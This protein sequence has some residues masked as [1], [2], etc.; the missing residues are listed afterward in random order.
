MLFGKIHDALSRALKRPRPA[1][2]QGEVWAI[3]EGLGARTRPAVQT[4]ACDRSTEAMRTGHRGGQAREPRPTRALRAGR[5]PD[6]MRPRGG[7]ELGSGTREGRWGGRRGS[8][9]RRRE[10][11]VRGLTARVLVYYYTDTVSGSLE[12]SQ[13]TYT[14]TR[15]VPPDPPAGGGSPSRTS[16][17]VAAYRGARHGRHPGA[18]RFLGNQPQRGDARHQGSQAKRVPAAP[19]PSGGAAAVQERPGLGAMA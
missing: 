13:W 19:C 1:A 15:T 7:P 4:P 14:W 9:G 2:L 5:H 3:L 12:K 8:A 6:L 11:C 10:R 17:R 18:G 16:S